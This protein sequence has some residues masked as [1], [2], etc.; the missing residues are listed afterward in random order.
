[1]HPRSPVSEGSGRTEILTETATQLVQRAVHQRIRMGIF[2][3]R[4]VNDVKA[5]QQQVELFTDITPG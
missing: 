2:A 3:L 5:I 1:M 4:M